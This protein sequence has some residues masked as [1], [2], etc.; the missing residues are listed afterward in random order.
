MWLI[1]RFEA[2][3]FFNEHYAGH[4]FGAVRALL[5]DELKSLRED[6]VGLMTA[7]ESVMAK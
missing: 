7:A 6:V 3:N 2:S 4:P 5:A 1:G